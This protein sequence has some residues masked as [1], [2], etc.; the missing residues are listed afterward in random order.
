M[1][2]IKSP[3]NLRIPFVLT[4]VLLQERQTVS[5]FSLSF[6][7]FLIMPIFSILFSI[8]KV[9]I[10]VIFLPRIVMKNF[11]TVSYNLG[12][13]YKAG[14]IFRRYLGGSKRGVKHHVGNYIR[15]FVQ[16]IL[17][18]FLKLLMLRKWTIF[19]KD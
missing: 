5:D 3:W 18:L 13:Y 9:F 7:L 2:Y 11:T 1:I 4:E 16:K 14:N 19:L 15:D 8:K 17:F 10:L 6:Y 12:N